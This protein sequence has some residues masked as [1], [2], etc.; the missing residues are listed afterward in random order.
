MFLVRGGRVQDIPGVQYRVIRGLL[1]YKPVDHHRT[2]RSKYSINECNNLEVLEPPVRWDD[3]MLGCQFACFAPGE[4]LAAQGEPLS[5]SWQTPYKHHVCRMLTTFGKL[6]PA[7]G[8]LRSL[9]DV[10]C[11]TGVADLSSWLR[12]AQQYLV[13][14]FEKIPWPTFLVTLGRKEAH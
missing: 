2:S 9:A 5:P 1:N 8:F 14:C 4:A 12:T 3:E 11:S 13:L 7:Q 10:A 6:G